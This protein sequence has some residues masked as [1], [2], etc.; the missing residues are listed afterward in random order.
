MKTDEIEEPA[1]PIGWYDNISEVGVQ[2]HTTQLNNLV[3]DIM[4]SKEEECESCAI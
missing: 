1:H 3:D 2:G 4:S